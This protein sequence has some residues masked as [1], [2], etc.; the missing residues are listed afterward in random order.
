MRTATV[1]V[2]LDPVDVHLAG[3]GHAVP[4]DARA[5]EVALPRLLDAFE[6]HA[7]RATFFVLGRDAD[8]AAAAL[9]SITA[10]GHEVASHSMDHPAGIG[11]LP[12]DALSQ[13][14]VMSRQEIEQAVGVP[15][16]G[17]RAPDWSIGR[18]IIAHLADA[19]YRY[20]ASLMPSP[21]LTAGRALLA[22]R[23]RRL[24]D[25]GILRLPASS[26]RDP[27]LWSDGGRP[28][29]EFPV[30]VTPLLRIPVYH[31]LRH[32]IGEARFRSIL[33]GIEAR[34]ESLSYPLHAVDALGLEEDG[35]D[36]R[37]RLHP[38]MRTPLASKLALLDST[39]AEIVAR[40]RAVAFIDRLP[41]ERR[42]T[43]T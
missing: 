31:T 3:Y 24:R 14:L 35:I 12:R 17:F 19:G 41:E 21:A 27:F 11:S 32:S 28:V 6:R 9:R 34:G 2:D 5:Y 16:V 36:P 20:D 26:R 43:R 22:M 39:L 30:T 8:R 13:Q 23:A 38:G 42:P 37:L 18:G 4:F 1:S 25:L 29:A 33:D 10:A 15:V 7:V 40:F